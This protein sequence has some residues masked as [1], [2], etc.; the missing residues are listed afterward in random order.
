MPGMRSGRRP[1]AYLP[2]HIAL[3]G[4]LGHLSGDEI[5]A[6][7]RGLNS[8]ARLGSVQRMPIKL[9]N[10]G[11]AV[12]DL[13]A[14]ISFFTDL[15]LTVLGRATVD[16]EWADTAV[17]RDGNH[18][19]IAMLQTP[20]GNGRL[21]LF[22][23]GQPGGCPVAIEKGRGSPDAARG[24]ERSNHRSLTP[25][26]DPVH[27]RCLEG[28]AITTHGYSLARGALRDRRTLADAE[29]APGAVATS[30]PVRAPT[31]AASR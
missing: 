27:Y 28:P 9:E 6:G 3:N 23:Y 29:V 22:E 1:T 31:E 16:G 17:G 21:G 25:A 19:N 4:L 11:I 8:S 24:F 13:E 5:S 15:G 2:R 7:S 12:R 18:A 20:D 14:A 10:V 30:A 26:S